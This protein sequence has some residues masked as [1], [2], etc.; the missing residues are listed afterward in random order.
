MKTKSTLIIACL[1]LA[2]LMIVGTMTAEAQCCWGDVIAAPFVAAGA[3]VEGAVAVSA[4]VV[5]APFT[6]LS[7]GNCGIDLC[8]PCSH[9]KV[10]W[11]PGNYGQF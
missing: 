8:N 9:P 6:A 11:V 2:F 10:S 5:T 3:I 4:A 1:A 7:S